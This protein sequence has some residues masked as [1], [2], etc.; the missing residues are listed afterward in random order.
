MSSPTPPRIGI[1]EIDKKYEILELLGEGGMGEI[2]KGRHLH[3]EEIRVLKTIRPQLRHDQELQARF[4]REA[5]V[6]TRLRHRN[7]A[8][9]HDFVLGD[10][11]TACIVMEFIEGMD[12][13]QRMRSA[14]PLKPPEILDVGRQTL[15]ALGYLHRRQII[16]RDISPDN[17]M[18]TE[19]RG[20]KLLVKLIDMGI[21]KPLDGSQWQTRSEMFI[22]K[23]SYSSPEQLGA[24]GAQ[25]LDGRSD[26]YSLGVVLCEALTGVLPITGT[27]QT[28]LIAGHLFHPPKSFDET[29]PRGAVS[30]ALRAVLTRA[31]EKKPEDRYA[32]AES[33][34]EALKQAL[35][36]SPERAVE[37]S[38]DKTVFDPID[39]GVAAPEG[40]PDPTR[41]QAPGQAAAG[42]AGTSEPLAPTVLEP[43]APGGGAPSQPPTV[44]TP[45]AEG[46]PPP[47]P[48]TIDAP[49]A[50]PPTVL[51]DGPPSAEPTAAPPLEPPT[52]GW[53]L[54]LPVA[55]GAVVVAAVIAV[56]MWMAS[57]AEERERA[58]L[59]ALD[60]GDFHAVVIGNDHYLYLPEL[61]TAARDA[62]DL[63]TLL[64]RRYGF[65][66]RVLQDATRNDIITSLSEVASALTP[67]DNLL[68]FYAG[69][70]RID[71]KNQ[72]G[73]WQPVDADPLD[74]SQWI[75]T[76]HTLS[77]LLDQSTAQR[78]LV[79]ADSCFSGALTSTAAR[80][81]A[82]D[83]SLTTADEIEEVLAYKARLALTSG[84]FSPVLDAGGGAHSIF[85]GEL[86]KILGE[87]D[88]VLT[89]SS[90]FQRA[91]DPV[92]AGSA[93]LG[94]SHRPQLAPIPRTDHSGGEFFFVPR[95]LSALEPRPGVRT[96]D[97]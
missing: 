74:T 94:I 73:F 35:E 10:D 92:A 76:T 88:G 18:L 15:S 67:R 29:D 51:S 31:I 86:L 64:E 45:P 79:I 23:V 7:I 70:G 58:D 50:Q 46:A 39:P 11:G 47:P 21:A 1:E 43:S 27:D 59:A 78:V 62:R 42:P 19:T 52:R 2:Y 84:G 24:G 30:P 71:A 90:L 44:L 91:V 82:S 13:A 16:H 81:D 65:R 95:D 75:S 25:E 77:S 80:V 66:V 38:F 54:G 96:A 69:H 14:R 89:V 40:A 87:N 60:Y 32:D 22:G 8:A 41:M 26:L 17:I 37:G 4:L 72:S 57:G 63:A 5:R 48:T 28:S 85:A 12:L 97:L 36:Q 9:I 6:A 53:R 68:V 55:L 20:K 61:E 93:A 49:R 56:A 83:E 3:L 33:F 34:A